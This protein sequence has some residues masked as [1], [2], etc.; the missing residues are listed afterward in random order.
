MSDCDC[1]PLAGSVYVV[2]ET[3][4]SDKNQSD[5]R[6]SINQLQLFVP[7][8]TAEQRDLLLGEL[9]TLLTLALKL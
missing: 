9:H 4:S 3:P 8:F 1:K 2:T 6:N 7:H 5:K